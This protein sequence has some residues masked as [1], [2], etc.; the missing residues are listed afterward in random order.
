M[1]SPDIRPGIRRLFR[2]A[3]RRPAHAADEMD[4]E[5]R[6]HLALRTEQLVREGRAPHAARAEAEARFGIPDEARRRL[7]HSARRREAH[8]DR[9]ERLDALSQDIRYAWRGLRRNPVFALVA[10]LTLALGIGANTAIFSLVD[11]VLLRSLPVHRPEQLVQITLGDVRNDE[12]TNPLWEAL[13]DRQDAFSGMF[14]FVGQR[15]DLAAGGVSRPVDGAWVSGGFFSVLGVRPAA[16][17]LLARADDHR[18][19]APVAVLDHGY[20][21]RAYGGD[22]GVVGRMIALNGHPFEIVGVADPAFSGVEVGRATQVYAPLCTKAIVDGG[23]GGLDNTS[24]WFLRIIGRR[25]DG[26]SE[27]AARAR[28]AAVAPAVFGATMPPDWPAERKRD[29]LQNQLDAYPAATGYSGLRFQYRDA[30]LALMAVVGLVLLVAC[31]NVANLLLA[32]AAARR[33]EIAIRMGIGAGRGRLVRHLLTES[34]LLA[35]AGGATGLLFARWA[36]GLLVRLLSARG[37]A[38]WLDTSIDGRL[39]AFTLAVSTATALLFGLAPAWR[40]TRVDLLAAMKTNDAAGG[41]G[42]G[43]VRFRSGKALVVGQIALSLVLVLGA[44]LL[45]GTFRTLATFDPGFTRDGVLLVSVDLRDAGYAPEATPLAKQAIVDRLRATPGVAHASAS[46]IT[47]ISGRGWNG[48]VSVDGY[49]PQGPHDAVVFINAVTDA[50]FATLGTPLRAGRDFDARDAAGAPPVAIV[51]EATARKFFHGANPI[52]R[53][54]A[55]HDSPDPTRSMEIVGVVRD[56]KYGSLREKTRELLYLPMAQNADRSPSLDLELRGA[57]PATA[58][59]PTVTAAMAAMDPRLSLRYTTLAAQVGASLAR[60]RLLATLS[61]FFGALALLL[62]MVGL[63]GTMAYTL[64]QRRRE[65]GVRLALGAAR[66]RVMRLV[67]GEVGRLVALGVVLG[68]AGAAAAARLMA[69]FLF[70]LSPADP[71]TW[72]LSAAVLSAVA[73][74]A[75]ALPAWRAATLDPVSAIRDA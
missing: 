20:W 19:C 72:A 7:H 47:P 43:P 53:R 22:A 18:G 9:G 61:G 65:I 4:D 2:L 50:Y 35:L 37:G 40:S 32:R 28:L 66:G 73:L 55:L 41:P 56:A 23:T 42:D 30:L 8:M 60:E 49:A 15:F 3:V 44:G 13:R 36:T 34:L 57:G 54:I 24:M 71:A 16:G 27:A 5:I 63:Y 67:L 39:L 70:G 11:A 21:Q 25:R 29:Y 12:F 51:N 74:A 46:A 75:G 64:A 14:A 58:L 38:V 69:P 6:L 48:E 17:R 26:V 45:L 68:A 1:R 33:R 62:A 10:A 31:A 52:G 59:V